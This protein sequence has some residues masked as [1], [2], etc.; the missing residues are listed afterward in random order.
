MAQNRDAGPERTQTGRYT[1]ANTGRRFGRKLLMLRSRELYS[2]LDYAVAVPGHHEVLR[3][4]RHGIKS[5]GPSLSRSWK[6]SSCADHATG[7]SHCCEI[8]NMGYSRASRHQN[9][10]LEN[11]SSVLSCAF[12]FL[13]SKHLL[14]ERGTPPNWFGITN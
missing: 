4:W 1:D 5:P 9:T 14:L 11:S 2:Q 6:L 10:L 13:Q 7:Q 12:G 8:L 3:F